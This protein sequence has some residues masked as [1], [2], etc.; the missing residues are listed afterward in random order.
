MYWLQP[1]L[2]VARI[3]GSR[4]YPLAEDLRLG[5]DPTKIGLVVK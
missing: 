2:Q 3:G 4:A 5:G 1:L